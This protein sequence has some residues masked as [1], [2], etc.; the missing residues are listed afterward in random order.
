MLA[1]L[2]PIAA[3][4]TIGALLLA[5]SGDEGEAD[6]GVF[7]DTFGGDDATKPPPPDTG[8]PTCQLGMP[9]T[10][11]SCTDVCPGNDDQ[12][13]QRTCEGRSCSVACKGEHYDADGKIENGCEAEDD[14]PLHETAET[15]VDLGEV[16]DCDDSGATVKGRIP[17]DSRDHLEDPE[18]RDEGRPDFYTLKIDDTYSI[19]CAFDP[20]FRLDATA[21]P[22]E[23]TLE[24]K[25]VYTCTNDE[26]KT[27]TAEASAVGGSS[28]EIE[29]DADCPGM[30]DDDAGTALIEI[31]KRGAGHSSADYALLYHG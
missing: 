2:R 26:T 14:L 21:L 7:P 8:G 12:A 1:T 22:P 31:Q 17:S 4:A 25:V 10:C 20:Y 3:V 6:A 9:N 11:A 24:I 23:V 18:Q 16:D 19:T 30:T 13:T 27:F 5:C 15:A 29:L 28:A